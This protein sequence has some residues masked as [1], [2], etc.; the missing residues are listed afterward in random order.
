MRLRASAW[1]AEHGLLDE[2]IEYALRSGD[3]AAAVQ[4]LVRHRYAMMNAGRCRRQ[5]RGHQRRKRGA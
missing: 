1:C 4:M 2:A 5:D 3:T